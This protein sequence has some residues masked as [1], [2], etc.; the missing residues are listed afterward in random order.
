MKSQTM[1]MTHGSLADK[2][3]FFVLPLIAA[4]MLQL[5]FNAADVIV[6][7]RFAGSLSLA[8]VGSTTS[9]IF[10]FINVLMGLSVGVNVMVA[11]YLG[12][13]EISGTDSRKGLFD[14]DRLTGSARM[15]SRTVH[16]AVSVGIIGGIGVGLLGILASGPVLRL[17]SVPENV[18]PLA[19][20]YMQIYFAGTA[21]NMLYNYGAAALRAQGDTQRPL[22]YLTISGILNVLLNLFFVIVLK[23]NV[24]GVALATISSQAVSAFLVLRCLAKMDSPLRLSIKK[25]CID[26]PILLD[27][28]RIGVPAGLQMCLFSVAN[29]TVQ[30]AINSYGDIIMAGASASTSIEGFMYAAMNAL[31][32]A[33]QT[34]TSQNVGAG[35]Y[36][37][38]DRVV[39]T[40]LLYTFVTAGFI[41]GIMYFFRYPLL[42]IYNTDPAVVEAGVTRLVIMV[43]P[44]F[45][46]GMADVFVGAIRGTGHALSP[47]ISTLL[48][49]CL[50][51]I[52]WT[53]WLDT[54]RFGVEWVYYSFPVTWFLLLIV[55]A[56]IWHMVRR[57][58]GWPTA[59]GIQ[60][61]TAEDC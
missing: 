51:R 22:F 26:L 20:L 52:L 21:F 61:K 8:A 9:A 10:L 23:M 30:G 1:D 12:M 42:R 40:C 7:G 49:T 13:A 2:L 44:Y 46:Y 57:K 31:H 50:L 18:F 14:P 58:A 47:V 48:C 33:S 53:L 27:M 36:D 41:A 16:T 54:G 25:L 28:A 6:V 56:A 24:A 29:M 37:R 32:Q 35:K 60:Q 45:L 3:I 43:V 59:E 15:I 5:L 4:N 55:V 19:R 11:R 38:V 34:F 17:M 39:R